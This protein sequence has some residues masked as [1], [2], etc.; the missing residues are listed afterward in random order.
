[1]V[2]HSAALV[3]IGIHRAINTGADATTLL[4]GM[5]PTVTVIVFGSVTEIDVLA[6]AYMRG[7][8]GLLLGTATGPG[9]RKTSGCRSNP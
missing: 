8:R 9:P 6:A 3:L 7:A 4:L 1:M 2:S 5:H